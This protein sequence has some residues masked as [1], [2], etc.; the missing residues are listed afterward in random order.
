MAVLKLGLIGAGGMGMSLA[1]AAKAREDVLFV[2]IADPVAEQASKAAAE[3]GGEVYS[4]YADLL[5]RKDLD[6]VLAATPNAAHCEVVLAAAAA[7]KHVFCE[8]PMALSVADCDR[9]IAAAQNAGVK[10]M[11]GQVLRLIPG[12]SKARELV[13]SGEFGKPLAIA[14][15]RSSFWRPRAWRREYQPTGGVLFE[16]NAHEIDYMRAILGDASS[17]YACIST[18]TCPD[19]DIPGINYVL[20]RFKDGGI[21]M[22]NSNS[23]IP[24][25]QYQVAI[26]LEKGSI[27]CDW[28]SVSYQFRDREAQTV[29]EEELKAMLP[30]VQRE[31]DSFVEWVLH[32]KEPLVT[33]LDGRSAVEIA[34]AALQSGATGQPVSLPLQSS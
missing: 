5:A 12:F 7:G 25:G 22:L 13:Q 29:P 24:Q 3:L 21:G 27:R 4:S 30:G 11:V 8:K 2:G 1:R 16:I 20:V 31:I 9:M 34:Q 33:A 28:S 18:E 32:G 26:T 14:I 17:V 15:E 10:L 19:S 6:A 23:L